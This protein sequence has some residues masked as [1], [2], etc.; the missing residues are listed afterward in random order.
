MSTFP[1]WKTIWLGTHKDIK[2][3][4]IAFMVAGTNVY[5]QV[6]SILSN[7]PLS[8]K[9][10]RIGLVKVTVAELGLRGGANYKYI[11]SRARELGLDYCPAEVG[12]QLI[13]Q[14][15]HRPYYECFHIAMEPV[16]TDVWEQHGLPLGA[17]SY[18]NESYHMVRLKPLFTLSYD[19]FGPQLGWA[20]AW[21]SYFYD[22]RYTFV[23]THRK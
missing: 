5:K 20:S 17:V 2:S 1:T 10:M 15:K 3:F 18:D 7:I 16:F 23:F 14:H 21:P 9:K 4:R 8:K 22:S 6:Y 19:T 13:L 11:I 12:P